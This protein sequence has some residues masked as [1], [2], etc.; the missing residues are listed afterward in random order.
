MVVAFEKLSKPD[1]ANL[2]VT[3]NHEQKSVPK[4]LLDDLEG[5]L[6]WGS[7]LPGE[8]IGA[9]S[10]RLIGVINSDIGEPF[11]GRVTRQG[12]PAVGKVCLT[13]PAIK[14]GLR[15]S[16]LVGRTILNRRE[17]EP[18]PLSG[19]D[20]AATLDRARSAINS[21]FQR[22]ENANPAQ[23]SAGAEG[24]L[25]N[26]VSIQAYLRLFAA[27]IEYLESNKGLSAREIEPDELIAELEEY[28]DPI[29]RFL[30]D[31]SSEQMEERF[32][33]Q[34]GSGGPPE[35]FFRLCVIVRDDFPDFSPEGFDDM[36]MV[37]SIENI[38]E[39]D[40][41]LKEL[42]ILVQKT[43][44]DIFKE[45]YQDKPDA[46]WHK[47]VIDKK[48]K[49]RAY[50][51][52]LDDDDDDR[53]P[54]ENY[55]DFIE[56][57]KIV[58]NKAHWSIFKALFDIPEPGEKGYSKNVRWMERV[59]ELR[60]IPAHPTERRG[61]KVGDFEYIDYIHGEFTNRLY[62]NGRLDNLEV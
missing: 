35:Y 29:L 61:Y 5:E 52:S 11:Y 48:I 59:N 6:K 27:T 28:L 43:I 44:F 37:R 40:R 46:Y 1:E 16:G 45:R 50:E 21:Y 23:W 60:R 8:R 3:I 9:I 17:Y 54:L 24:F 30:S 20:D 15:R 31:A 2:F 53:L 10:A 7:K 33:V 13:V 58:E 38:A 18:G 57:K 42:N 22:L 19:V 4:T 49:T 25:C 14:D 12:I 41:K 34:F 32:K 39:A 36:A 56:Y 51:K 47:G 55:L 62:E 26:N